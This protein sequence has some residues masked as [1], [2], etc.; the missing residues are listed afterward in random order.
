[1]GVSVYRHKVIA[2]VISAGF[3][4]LAGALYSFA[5]QY[6]SPNTYSFE[7]T[8]LFLLAISMGGRKTRT[9]AILGAWIIV[10]LPKSLVR[11]APAQIAASGI[12]RTFYN[13]QLFGEMT[14]LENVLVEQFASAAL[15]VA[16]YGYVLEN[17]RIS[18]HGDTARL[19]ND[20]AVVAAYLGGH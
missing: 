4:G 15:N 2:F 9:G 18:V 5:E 3:A 14:A 11:L 7:L 1:M 19:N 17:G 10:P 8:I 16:D 13:V 12:A 6:S 20:P